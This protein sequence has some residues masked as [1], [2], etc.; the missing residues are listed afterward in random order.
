MAKNELVSLA[1]IFSEPRHAYA[2]NA[3]IKEICLDHW[4]HISQA[5]IYNTLSRLAQAGCVD[6][7]N[8]RVGNN[9]ER[10]VYS[11]TEAGR[12]RLR[13]ELREALV[14]PSAGDNPFY[15]ATM[16]AF[17]LPA[18]E[19]IA[20]LGERIKRLESAIEHMSDER[21]HLEEAGAKQALIMIE[22]AQEHVG[23]E[24][25]AARCLGALLRED[26]EFYQ[27]TVTRQLREMHD[28]TGGSGDGD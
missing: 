3:I 19:V 18:D 14:T 8:E 23:V 25:K 7:T 16:F 4:A 26:P 15:L 22:A 1:L 17:G 2:L 6:V 10:K 12:E 24:L 11:I 27:Q 13:Q 20:L 28:D 9:P 21:R 5:S